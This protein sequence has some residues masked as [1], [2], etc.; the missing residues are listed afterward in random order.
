MTSSSR[1][2]DLEALRDALIARLTRRS[3]DFDA[4]RE[5]RLVYASLQHTSQG[6]QAVTTSS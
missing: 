3:D 1:R 5:L 4:T 2:E 6:K